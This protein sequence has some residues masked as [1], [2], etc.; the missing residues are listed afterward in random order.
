MVYG[1]CIEKNLKLSNI[2]TNKFLELYP[3]LREP[4][5]D[6]IVKIVTLYDNSHRKVSSW[7]YKIGDT[8]KISGIV[9]E[10]LYY[11]FF[12]RYNKFYYVCRE[13]FI[14]LKFSKHEK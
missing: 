10:K 2:M 1:P 9:S 6:D 14:L 4:Q 5:V 11:I 3:T 7:L 8:G 13:E 12:P